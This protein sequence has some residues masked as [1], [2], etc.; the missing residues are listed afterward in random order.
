M[1]VRGEPLCCSKRSEEDK[2]VFFVKSSNEL[3]QISSNIISFTGTQ[4]PFNYHPAWLREGL[5]KAVMTLPVHAVTACLARTKLS[6]SCTFLEYPFS[7]RPFVTAWTCAQVRGG[8]SE[9]GHPGRY[10]PRERSCACQVVGQRPSIQSQK[11]FPS[12]LQEHT[13]A[14]ALFHFL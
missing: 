6:T 7:A 9:S 5:S 2:G 1:A 13:T 3:M 10:M 11:A 14:Q 8:H 4:L 12:N